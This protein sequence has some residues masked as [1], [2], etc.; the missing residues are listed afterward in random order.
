MSMCCLRKRKKTVWHSNT[1]R[2]DNPNNRQTEVA[3]SW[4][5]PQKSEK[6]TL[7]RQKP[8][9]ET[10]R[11]RLFVCL[12]ERP[13]IWCNAL[14]VCVKGGPVSRAVFDEKTPMPWCQKPKQQEQNHKPRIWKTWTSNVCLYEFQPN[15]FGDKWCWTIFPVGLASTQ[16]IKSMPKS[17]WIRMKIHHK[18]FENHHGQSWWWRFSG[19]LLD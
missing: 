8:Q 12:H 16:L 17:N 3:V 6:N 18:S 13:L 19:I 14:S 10:W 1:A 11:S 4:V 7:I 9:T 2:I 5:F 15:T